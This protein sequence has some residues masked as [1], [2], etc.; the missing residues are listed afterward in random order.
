[1]VVCFNDTIS[2]QYF[3][4]LR[5]VSYIFLFYM[6]TGMFCA[7][8]IKCHAKFVII[9]SSILRIICFITSLLYKLYITIETK[10][11][12]RVEYKRFLFPH[13]YSGECL[14]ATYIFGPR[15]SFAN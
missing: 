11:V 12:T 3:N 14:G 5:Y 1:M 2:R 10:E 9:F 15:L 13:W 8:K 4:G 7:N 6:Y